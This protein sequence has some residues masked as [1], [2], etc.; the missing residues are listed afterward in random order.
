MTKRIPLTRGKF[1][2]VSDEDFDT[3]SQYNWLCYRNGYACRQGPRQG[4]NRTLILMHR[5]IMDAPDGL[6]VDHI[7]GDTLDNRRENLRLCTH[8]ENVMNRPG[9]GG[10]SKF[11]GVYHDKRRDRY[12]ATH[13]GKHIGS[14]RCEEDAARA[15][16][17]HVKELHGEYAWLNFPDTEQFDRDKFESAIPTVGRVSKPRDPKQGRTKRAKR[18]T[19]Q[20]DWCGADIVRTEHYATRYPHNFCN[21]SCWAS[22]TNRQQTKKRQASKRENQHD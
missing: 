17:D 6:N 8:Q 14:F 21:K 16:D 3:L 22:F 15:Y 13:A 5:V 2:L 1:A 7:N 4:N 10:S 18:V 9:Y 19:V 12:Y 11:K 20:C